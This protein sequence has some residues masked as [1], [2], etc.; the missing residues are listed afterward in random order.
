V[1]RYRAVSDIYRNRV[2]NFDAQLILTAYGI[3][4]GAAA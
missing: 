2:A 1:K 4:M 3:F